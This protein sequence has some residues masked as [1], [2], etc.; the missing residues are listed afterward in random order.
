MATNLSL[1]IYDVSGTM[2][3]IKLM[4]VGFGTG[5]TAG[6][7]GARRTSFQGSVD[8]LDPYWNSISVRSASDSF[9]TG[10]TAG[11]FW[12]CLNCC[13]SAT[14]PELAN[15]STC[16][17]TVCDR[18]NWNRISAEVETVDWPLKTRLSCSTAPQLWSQRPL[19]H[20]HSDF[21]ED[22]CLVIPQSLYVIRTQ[23]LRFADRILQFY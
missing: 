12:S 3:V 21:S 14:A 4:W 23:N 16:H 13:Q 22:S 2:F 18:S 10:W 9:V 15:R 7:C 1:K 17:K 6:G 11:E 19:P 20:S 5:S 8:S